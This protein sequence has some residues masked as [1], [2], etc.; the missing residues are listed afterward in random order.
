MK[1]KDNLEIHFLYPTISKTYEDIFSGGRR[2]STLAM[3]TGYN[4]RRAS[5]ERG[6]WFGISILG[7]GVGFYWDF[8][9]RGWEV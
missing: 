2:G 9:G 5:E 4:W 1:L 3:D 7:F 8:K 6:S